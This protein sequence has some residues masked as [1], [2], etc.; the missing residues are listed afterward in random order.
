MFAFALS[1]SH[2]FILA[3]VFLIVFGSKRLPDLA[4]NLGKSMGALRK[5]KREFEEELL[6]AQTPEPPATA[7]T[8]TPA[9]NPAPAAETP[10]QPTTPAPEE[11]KDEA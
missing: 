8:T 7:A 1:P 9:A 10:A 5:A 4:R 11:K 3:I 6:K 2:W